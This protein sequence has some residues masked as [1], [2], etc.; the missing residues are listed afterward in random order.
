MRKKQKKTK[1]NFL[2]TCIVDRFRLCT[3]FHS[4]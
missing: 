3:V 1:K 4:N 2:I